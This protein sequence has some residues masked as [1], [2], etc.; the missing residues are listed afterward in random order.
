DACIHH[1]GIAQ[2]WLEMPDALE[3]PRVRRAVVPLMC[4]RNAVVHELA[5]DR[6]P[7]LA[8]VVRALNQLPEPGRALR[9]ID[10]VPIGGP[11]LSGGDFPTAEMGA[12]HFPPV[13]LAVRRQHQRALAASSEHTDSPPQ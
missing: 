1:I 7:R 11:T 6:F 13:A 10:A 9:A 2:R 5:V 8:A 3:L 4:A 12:P